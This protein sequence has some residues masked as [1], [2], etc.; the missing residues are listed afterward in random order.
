MIRGSAFSSRFRFQCFIYV[1]G[2]FPLVTQHLEFEMASD[3]LYLFATNVLAPWII[4]VI[5]FL[6]VLIGAFMGYAI[7]SAVR[8]RHK[9]EKLAI[10][11]QEVQ[12]EQNKLVTFDDV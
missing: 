12:D 9:L 7:A 6:F 5:S 2:F 3:N 10:Y 11:M 1:H 4:G 8:L